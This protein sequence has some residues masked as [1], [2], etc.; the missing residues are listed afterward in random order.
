ML[1]FKKRRFLGIL[2]SALICVTA[3]SQIV[4]AEEEESTIPQIGA[5]TNV[6]IENLAEFTYGVQKAYNNLEENTSATKP[7]IAKVTEGGVSCLSYTPA[8]TNTYG[9]IEF[10]VNIA[11][12]GVY[13]VDMRAK[14][15]TGGNQAYIYIDGTKIGYETSTANR[16]DTV[17]Y[18]EPF[19]FGSC[20][21]IAG[22]HTVRIVFR[23][24]GAQFWADYVRFT[25]NEIFAP[26]VQ[27]KSANTTQVGSGSVY[28]YTITKNLAVNEWFSMTFNTDMKTKYDIYTYI[29]VDASTARKY[30]VYLD[31]N[32]LNETLDLSEYEAGVHKVLLASDVLL[33]INSH[34]VK[35]V[36][37]DVSGGT[38]ITVADLF[39]LKR[40]APTA[41][42]ASQPV[43]TT[44]TTVYA[45]EQTVEIEDIENITYHGT[46]NEIDTAMLGDYNGNKAFV[47]SSASSD[48]GYV[49]IPINVEK[50]GDYLV[51]LYYTTADLTSVTKYEDYD[52]KN[53][54]W[55]KYVLNVNGVN[56]GISKYHFQDN[57]SYAQFGSYSFG[58]QNAYMQ[59]GVN[60]IRVYNEEACNGYIVLDKIVLIPNELAKEYINAFDSELTVLPSSATTDSQYI[61]TTAIWNNTASAP[62][63][64]RRFHPHGYSADTE[65]SVTMN[66]N[67]LNSAEYTVTVN[68]AYSRTSASGIWDVYANNTKVGTINFYKINNSTTDKSMHD[69]TLSSAAFTAGENTIKFVLTGM[70]NTSADASADQS[71]SMAFS[72]IILT[73]VIVPGEIS[74]LPASGRAYA[75]SDI[76]NYTGR[77]KEAVIIKA[78]YEEIDG[79]AV[80]KDCE[81]L[82]EISAEAG[83]SERVVVP[84]TGNKGEIIKLFIWEDMENCVPLSDAGVIE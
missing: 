61:N 62:E 37:T 50:T 12:E 20:N 42:T 19:L 7:T 22:E 59:D 6:Q 68:N 48:A 69:I 17:W 83:Y 1:K 34:T 23:D 30:K 5:M 11:S 55:G 46:R 14:A 58:G 43:F 82:E 4:F 29:K 54:N 9:Y 79:V 39:R 52:V 60:T 49:E 80:L 18:S 65:Y 51:Y 26:T 35:F 63:K 2:L 73:P 75:Y 84:V 64:V 15:K 70:G 56:R 81:V 41:L 66:V 3:A 45:T 25:K 36:C 8:A 78:V 21:L 53:Y 47:I 74:V 77:D 57:A 32:E 72:N 71:Y 13:A 76:E 44:N 10:K 67:V 24:Q 27:S 33:D 16:P 38:Q 40:Y 31:E 28:Q